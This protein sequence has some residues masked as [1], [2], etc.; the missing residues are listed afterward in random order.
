MQPAT[1]PAA[2]DDGFYP[3][4]RDMP[5]TATQSEPRD[6]G[7]E[8]SFVMTDGQKLFR[9][10]AQLGALDAI[11]PDRTQSRNDRLQRFL[12]YRR[13]FEAVASELYDAGLPPRIT[14]DHLAHLPR[15]RRASAEGN[16]GR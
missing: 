2:Q 3:C 13:V 11:E 5:L 6:E 14:V 10:S 7:F 16:S 1:G 8:V 12:R 4:G 15:H 9:C